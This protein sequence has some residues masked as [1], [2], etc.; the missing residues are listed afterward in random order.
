MLRRYLGQQQRL[1][2]GYMPQNQYFERKLEK[3]ERKETLKMILKY[4]ILEM[5]R[6]KKW[7]A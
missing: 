4:H 7:Q 5:V 6:E 1:V 3:E 2:K